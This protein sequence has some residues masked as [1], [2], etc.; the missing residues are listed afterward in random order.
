MSQRTLFVPILALCLCAGAPA[1][2]AQP[3][4]ALV[5]TLHK[6]SGGPDGQYPYLSLVVGKNNDLYGA[7]PTGG[8][9]G[10]GT[11]FKINRDGTGFSVIH[12][13]S[14]AEIRNQGLNRSQPGSCL[15]Q[16]RDGKLYGT[17]PGS[18]AGTI[19]TNGM[20]YT[21]NTDGSSFAVL[22]SFANTDGGPL[23]LIQG[24]DGMLYGA[25]LAIFKMD[26]SGGNYSVLHTFNQNTDGAAPIGKLLQ[27]DD[28]WLYGTTEIGGS[29]NAGTI[30][31][32]TTNGE[33]F[34]VL[35]V[36]GAGSDGKNPWAG[37]IEGTDGA[38]YG[39]TFGGG[40]NTYGT[41]FTIGRDGNN[42]QVLHHFT[43]DGVDGLQPYGPLVQ[44]L[45]NRL[46]GTT[47]GG[48][49]G[50]E[51]TIFEIGLNGSGYQILYS[52]SSSSEQNQLYAGLVQGPASDGSGVLYG[53]SRSGVQFYGT[54]FAIIVNPPV[55]I[56][57]AVGQSG[58]QP[59]VFWPEWAVNY[60][61]QTATNL[62]G[63]WTTT[64][65]YIPATAAILTNN[66]PAAFYRLVWPQ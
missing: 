46:Y 64:S 51:G 32:I 12:S 36:F 59:V 21:L 37:V 27:A 58:S 25:G 35:H 48:G 16:G 2:F 63:P 38:L 42:Y 44:G 43:Y 9:N 34:T 24:S 10:Y 15:I 19:Y 20:I 57:P 54:I 6:F 60:Q 56:T 53:M 65:N 3:Q 4:P 62:N 11:I 14:N 23:S 40:T 50:N 41:I 28:G 29:N 22:H 7:T 18:S 26:T 61:L 39:V 66:Q 17:S 52:P 30:F 47:P 8:T 5:E 45:N 33:N 13:F 31:K 1:L 49:L 55:S